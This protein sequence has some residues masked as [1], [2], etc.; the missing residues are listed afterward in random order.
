MKKPNYKVGKSIP[1]PATFKWLDE[2]TCELD[3]V[4]GPVT[5]TV[6]GMASA[7]ELVIDDI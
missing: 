6:G 4:Q 7:L 2:S 1:F 5:K 3:P